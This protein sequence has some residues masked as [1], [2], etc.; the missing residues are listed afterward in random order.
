MTSPVLEI[1]N[2]TVAIAGGGDRANAIENISLSVMPGEIVC[3]VGESGSGK[4]VTS[5]AVMA[6]LPKGQ[7]KLASGSIKLEGDELTTKSPPDMRR[8]RGMRAAMVFQEPMTALNPV[9]RCGDQIG[10][11]LEIHTDLDASARRARVLDVM[12]SVH[13]P[14]P[15]QMIDA[16]PHSSPAANAN[17]S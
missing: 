5:Q 3:V 15:E 12:R 7:L 11:V 14:D 8:V 13:L 9:E 2:L 16:Y 10:E 1:T 6:L 4:S 17:A